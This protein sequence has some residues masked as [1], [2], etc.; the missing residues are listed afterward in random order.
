MLWYVPPADNKMLWL[1]GEAS[2]PL[3]LRGTPLWTARPRPVDDLAP[4]VD[5]RVEARWTDRRG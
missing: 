5:G 3:G 1:T 4:S 2:V